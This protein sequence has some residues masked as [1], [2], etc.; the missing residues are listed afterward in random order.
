MMSGTRCDQ[1]TLGATVS[2]MADFLKRQREELGI[3]YVG[4]SDIDREPE[5]WAPLVEALT[6]T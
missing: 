4:F 6:G 2:E 1:Y 5:A 3:S